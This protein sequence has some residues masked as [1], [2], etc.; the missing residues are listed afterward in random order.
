[1]TMADGIAL[2]E[3]LRLRAILEAVNSKSREAMFTL[4]GT[5]KNREVRDRC[6]SE[7]NAA[8]SEFWKP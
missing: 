6:L 4:P 2:K 3:I 1:M 5:R 7:I 8:T